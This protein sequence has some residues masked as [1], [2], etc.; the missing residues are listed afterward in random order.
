MDDFL[1]FWLIWS[2]FRKSFS[3]SYLK[4]CPNESFWFSAQNSQGTLRKRKKSSKEVNNTWWH[5]HLTLRWLKIRIEPFSF[6]WTIAQKI[7]MWCCLEMGYFFSKTLRWFNFK[8]FC[9]QAFLTHFWPVLCLFFWL[10]FDSFLM[11]WIWRK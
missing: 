10:S 3:E 5:M 9:S 7:I 6:F 8:C 2:F 11:N 1:W 4:I